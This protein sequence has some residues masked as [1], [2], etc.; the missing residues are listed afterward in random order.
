MENKEYCPH[1][2]SFCDPPAGG[3][4][5]CSKL[6]PT[7]F[8]SH[9]QKRPSLFTGSDTTGEK[10]FEEF[11]TDKEILDFKRFQNLSNKE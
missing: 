9:A 2:A 5:D 3:E 10:D 7:A 6:T 1:G 11:F 8:S 4:A